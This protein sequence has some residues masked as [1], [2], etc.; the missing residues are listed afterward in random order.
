MSRE[1][2]FRAKIEGKVIYSSG[3]MK[4]TNG[5]VIV[6]TKFMDDFFET[7]PIDEGTLEQFTGLKDKNGVDIY[8]G[9]I[10][11]CVTLKEYITHKQMHG[12]R[13]VVY[14]TDKGCFFYKNYIPMDWGGISYYE[15]TG[16]IHENK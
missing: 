4:H 14:D 10:V 3:F 9:D 12:I 1:I 11:N 2:K 5:T 16:N 13:E 7:S 6:I 15:V 8:E